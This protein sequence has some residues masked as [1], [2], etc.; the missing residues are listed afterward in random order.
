MTLPAPPRD[1][2][3]LA[4]FPF[5]QVPADFPYARI[6]HDRFEP[7]WFCHC[8]QCRFDPPTGG[9][10]GTCYLAGHPLGA[11]VEKFGRLRVVP[12]SLVD[13]HALAALQ[14]PS[15]LRVADVTDRRIL[16]RWHLSAELWAGDDYAGSQRWAE[17]LHQAGF[18]GIWYSAR[19]DVRGGLH[20]L[21][22]FGK[23]GHQPDALL[24]Y[25]DE[26]IPQWLL[27]E[28]AVTFGIE[29][30]PTGGTL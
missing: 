17:R 16:G 25:S 1:P 9:S 7:E 23:P 22:I 2:A 5:R 6:H 21:A 20:N 14:L 12:R 24:R 18:A 15:P 8:G 29:T 11:F 4:D 27:H 26:P 28:A 30:L 19:H 10:F 13:Q 3:E